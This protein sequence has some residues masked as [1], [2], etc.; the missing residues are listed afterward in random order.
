MKVVMNRCPEIETAGCVRIVLD[1]IDSAPYLQARA[2]F[3]K[4]VQ[5]MSLD[6]TTSQGGVTD[7]TD[8]AQ[9]D[10]EADA[11]AKSQHD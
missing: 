2:G 10:N 6:R 3:G 7:A 11:S 8:R 1:G 9:K 4:G 5:R